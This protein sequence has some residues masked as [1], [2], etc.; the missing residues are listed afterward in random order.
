MRR[1]RD[2][3]V[4]EEWLE[5]DLFVAMKTVG[6]V[7]FRGRTTYFASTILFGFRLL[8]CWY[9]VVETPVHETRDFLNRNNGDEFRVTKVS[10]DGE[11]QNPRC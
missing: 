3:R 10:R 5:A 11:H 7:R 8:C 9:F 1:E 4:F 6:R 2:E